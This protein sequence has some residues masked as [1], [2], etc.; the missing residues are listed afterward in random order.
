MII[1]AARPQSNFYILDKQISENARLSWAA[2]G[3]LVYLLGK[4][5]H[6]QVSVPA[7]V[8]ETK[9]AS[10]PMGRDAVLGLLR[11]LS[12]VGYCRRQQAHKPDGTL[13]DMRYIVSEEMALAPCPDLP[14]AADPVTAEPGAANPTL[15]ST[16]SLVST[17]KEARTKIKTPAFVLPDW[18]PEDAWAAF[19]QI[20]KTKKSQNTDYALGLLVKGLARFKAEGYDPVE[21]I[22]TSIRSGWSDVYKPRYVPPVNP[23]NRPPTRAD[24]RAATFAGLT[25]TGEH[26]ASNDENIIDIDARV[27]A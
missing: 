7:L 4:P 1:R 6:W 9:E 26:H 10:R 8:N 22:N 24:L 15:V 2:R 23:G 17:E 14:G 18:I 27:A 13:G 3:L 20:R 21:I 16:E 12:E 11:E 19:M 25:N 5:D